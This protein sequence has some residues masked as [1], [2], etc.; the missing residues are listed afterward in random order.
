M[1]KNTLSK[2]LKEGFQALLAKD[3][4]P[5]DAKLYQKAFAKYKRM[6]NQYSSFECY[7][8]ESGL[9][10]AIADVYEF[11]EESRNNV[12]NTENRQRYQNQRNQ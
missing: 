6:C 7:T 1:P 8:E 5:F 10:N 4:I 2:D 12:Q 11:Y 9:E 3:S